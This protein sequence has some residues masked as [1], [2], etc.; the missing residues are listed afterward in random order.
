MTSGTPCWPVAPVSTPTPTPYPAC[1]RTLHCRT[2]GFTVGTGGDTG[3]GA[4]DVPK[5]HVTVLEI[6]SKDAP[7]DPARDPIMVRVAQL[8]GEGLDGPQAATGA[9][10]GDK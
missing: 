2:L 6:P 1:S 5:T 9:A 3:S 10:A 4:G 8:L 7:Y